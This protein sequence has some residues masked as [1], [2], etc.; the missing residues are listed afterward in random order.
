[1][2]HREPKQKNSFDR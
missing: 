2:K 1:M